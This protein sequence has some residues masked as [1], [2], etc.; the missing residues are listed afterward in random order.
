MNET[1]N[2]TLGL[3]GL[4]ESAISG[5]AGAWCDETTRHL[6]MIPEL[7]AVFAHTLN[8][9]IEDAKRFAR[10]EEFYRDLLDQ[11][12]VHLGPEAYT[13][14]TGGVHDEPIRLKIPEIVEKLVRKASTKS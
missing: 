2:R 9:W 14:D 3:E 7:A 5:A 8:A 13:D 10:N 4:N 11:C 6:T 1:S 12:A